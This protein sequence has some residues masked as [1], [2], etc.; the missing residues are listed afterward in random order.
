MMFKMMKKVMVV[1]A[2]MLGSTAVSSAITATEA[3]AG[4]CGGNH[5]RACTMFER[6]G[7]PCNS[8]LKLTA[9]VGGKCTKKKAR[10]VISLPVNPPKIELPKIELPTVQLPTVQL[11]VVTRDQKL[12]RLSA[13]YTDA[14]AGHQRA[15]DA[16]MTCMRRPN[17]I[18]RYRTSVK[19]RD[20]G[21]ASR[22]MSGCLTSSSRAA[23]KK[24][25]HGSGSSSK[26]FNTL[27]IGL[28]AGGMYGVG[29][30]AEGG[31]AH[32]LN[33]RVQTRPYLAGAGSGGFGASAG[34][35]IV[36]TLSRDS[37]KR[38]GQWGVDVAAAGKYLGGGGLSI[39]Y[40]A[41][42]PFKQDP[43]DGFSI[44]GGVG[45]GFQVGTIHPNYTQTF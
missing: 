32:D 19:L 13:L 42:N 36:L 2:L 33:G 4:S 23:L 28:G 22:V 41:V 39:N 10:P 37:V 11:P 18:E 35:D 6:P 20:A 26:F 14:T 25:P 43:F 9:A 5:Q 27:T 38:G 1:T 24:A 45:L 44:F 3:Q 16:I 7:K 15:L 8:G 34:V 30:E 40:D 29:L 17:N 12:R 31:W 21:L